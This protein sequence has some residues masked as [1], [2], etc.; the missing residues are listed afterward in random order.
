MKR[1]RLTVCLLVMCMALTCVGIGIGSFAFA[2]EV[3]QSVDANGWNTAVTRGGDIADGGHTI[4]EDGLTTYTNV[5]AGDKIT[6]ASEIGIPFLDVD[7]EEEPFTPQEYSDVPLLLGMQAKGTGQIKWTI[8][9]YKITDANR[10]KSSN[11]VDM[12]SGTMQI[13][14]NSFAAN[15][16]LDSNGTKQRIIA[17]GEPLDLLF[18]RLSAFGGTIYYANEVNFV[19]PYYPGANYQ[20]AVMGGGGFQS[21]GITSPAGSCW[22]GPSEVFVTFEIIGEVE[23]VSVRCQQGLLFNSDTETGLTGSAAIAYDYD[24]SY[25]VFGHPFI[26]VDNKNQPSA[27]RYVFANYPTAF[28]LSNPGDKPYVTVGGNRIDVDKDGFYKVMLPANATSARLQM[29]TADYTVTYMDGSE[30]LLMNY[31]MS[32]EKATA[33][34][35]EKKGGVVNKWYSDSTLSKE[36]N[37]ENSITGDTILYAEWRDIPAVTFKADGE[38]YSW[39]NIESGG[40]A[41]RPSGTPTKTDMEFMGWYADEECTE[42]FDFTTPVTENITVYA[43]FGYAVTFKL[44]RYNATDAHSHSVKMLVASGTKLTEEEAPSFGEVL[45]LGEYANVAVTWYTDDTLKTAVDFGAD[46]VQINSDT[47]MVGAVSDISLDSDDLGVDP[48]Q[49][50]WDTNKSARYDKNGSQLTQLDAVHTGATYGNYEGLIADLDDGFSRVNLNYVGYI[51]NTRSFDVTKDIYFSYS[52]DVKDD[53]AIWG[54]NK[55]GRRLNFNIYNNIAGA[56][57]S[58]SQGYNG[59]WGAV[60]TFWHYPDNDETTMRAYSA[61]DNSDVAGAGAFAYAQETMINLRIAIGE[62]STTIYQIVDGSDDVALLTLDD[63]NRSHFPNG[64]AYFALAPFRATTFDIR[65]TQEASAVKGTVEN[66]TFEMQLEDK[67]YIAGDK[68]YFTA[69]PAA[70]YRFSMNGLF[71][72]G[73]QLTVKQDGDKYYFNMPFGMDSEISLKFG[74]TV[75]FMDGETELEIPDI[76][77]DYV[78]LTGDTVDRFYVPDIPAKTGYV[79]DTWCTDAALTQP[80]DMSTPVTANLTLYL[81]YKPATYT[82]TFISNGATYTTSTAEY[83]GKVAVPEAPT[84]EGYTFEGWYTDAA[85]TTAYDFDTTVTSAISLY[86]NWTA[87]QNEDNGG[88]GG[89]NS[90]SAGGAAAAAIALLVAGTAVVITRRK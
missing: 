2:D 50:G 26:G 9:A 33:P 48:E 65:I 19:T 77:G 51:V 25:G 31:V 17:E 6:Y 18:A 1:V 13:G 10:T 63:V 53:P 27:N 32:G 66:G 4:N 59:K 56:M 12:Y 52:V 21:A 7:W 75:K 40:T 45:G 34:T 20:A 8:S 76:T 15:Y 55:N 90:A 30:S 82:I 58:S 23:E 3:T 44:F 39:Q 70:G 85:C 43:G 49:N 80:F 46:G 22:M 24:Q 42:L 38:E 78:V 60:T 69:V 14:G 35:F 37:F 83:N 84:R 16:A 61:A 28:K 73:K 62:D 5:Q 81:R 71:A 88:C 64:Y 67:T 11:I 89:C 36:F 41:I 79:F 86:A 47:A 74:V 87:I 57:I 29:S 72:D 54:D 68:V